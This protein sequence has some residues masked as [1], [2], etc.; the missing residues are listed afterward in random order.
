MLEIFGIR[1]DEINFNESKQIIENFL[2]TDGVKSI[3]TPN[4][5]I[6]MRSR[7]NKYLRDIINKANLVTADGI[8]IVYA[9]RVK[10]Y[11]LEERVTGY[12]MS[13]YMLELANKLGYSVY[14][15]GSREGVA[16]KAAE[17]IKKQYK[18][19][20][21]AGYH[22]GFFKG[23]QNNN[24]DHD[25]ELN[26]ISDINRS[27]ADIV[28]VGLGFPRQ[29]IWIH[30]NKDRLKCKVVIGN[31]GVIDILAGEST[32]APEIWQKLGLEW[33]YRL[34]K[35]PSR[36]KRQ[37]ILPKFMLEVIFRRDIVKKIK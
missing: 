19:I 31:G 26:I 34:I 32:R 27:A 4:P 10:G 25:E 30:E 28:F 11:P 29:E 22:N 36:I 15:L 12:D 6:V 9:S 18:N 14:L 20:K 21:V 7:D 17:N 2:I 13:I 35:E 23:V 8:G 5:E 16:K 33:F 3:Y 24:K 1:I 37:L